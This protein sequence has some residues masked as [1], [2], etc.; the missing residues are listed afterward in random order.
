MDIHNEVAYLKRY[1]KTENPFDIIR[2]KKFFSYLKNLA[3]SGDTTILYCVKNKYILTVILKALSVFLLPLMSW[4]MPL[5]TL[6][7]IHLFYLQILT[8]LWID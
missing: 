3:L 8:S 2:A 1:Y 6:K 7:Q 5:C 4:A